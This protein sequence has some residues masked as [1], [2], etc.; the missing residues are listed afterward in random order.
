MVAYSAKIDVEDGRWLIEFPDCPGCQT[1]AETEVEI[2]AR[3]REALE[4]WLEATLEMGH[5]PPQPV[6]KEARQLVTFPAIRGELLQIVVSEQLALGLRCLWNFRQRMQCVRLEFT[7]RAKELYEERPKAA[8]AYDSAEEILGSV[9]REFQPTADTAEQTRRRAVQ[10]TITQLAATK[11]AFLADWASLMGLVASLDGAED[12]VTVAKAALDLEYQLT[13]DTEHVGPLADLLGV[14]ENYD[15]N[16][17][18]ADAMAA[19]AKAADEPRIL[20]NKPKPEDEG[21][22]DV[23]Q[24]SRL[25]L[26][27]VRRGVASLADNNA[28]LVPLFVH[29]EQVP[30]VRA[31]FESVPVEGYD[32][33]GEIEE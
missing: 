4:G 14:G 20:L 8:A 30:A 12:V 23:A 3:A 1:F 33:N 10:Q 18:G 27:D 15:E 17:E 6:S 19:L 2:I 29:P 5:I 13:G 22:D 24:N 28:Q 25:T 31:L 32:E 9:I 11:D 16:E 21:V 26:E 7:H